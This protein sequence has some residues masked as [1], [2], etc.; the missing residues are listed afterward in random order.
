MINK[1]NE[2]KWYSSHCWPIRWLVT[3]TSAKCSTWHNVQLK[4]YIYWFFTIWQGS[5]NRYPDVPELAISPVG[6][7]QSISA[8]HHCIYMIIFLKYFFAFYISFI[9]FYWIF[10]NYFMRSALFF[11]TNLRLLTEI[12]PSNS[13][14]RE[15]RCLAGVV[16]NNC[17]NVLLPSLLPSHQV[18]C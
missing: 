12:T 10:S 3:T 9:N 7:P 18:I 13:C 2:C 17:L 16:E 8:L 15:L 11:L 5:Q 4:D 6:R 1:I 14:Y